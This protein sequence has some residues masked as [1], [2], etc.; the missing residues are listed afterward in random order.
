MILRSGVPFIPLSSA[1]FP[2]NGGVHS[3]DSAGPRLRESGGS[4][5]TVLS[6]VPLRFDPVISSRS[7]LL[8]F[9]CPIDSRSE[10]LYRILDR[11]KMI[12]VVLQSMDRWCLS[13]IGLH[14]FWAPR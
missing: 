2:G 14:R 8:L 6:P 12:V 9:H 7:T 4:D 10:I 13:F 1:L 3:T 5:S 11:S